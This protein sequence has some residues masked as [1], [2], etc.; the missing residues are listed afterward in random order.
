MNFNY[1]QP[2]GE[3]VTN[4]NKVIKNEI[5]NHRAKVKIV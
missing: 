4:I 1:N 3:Q 2:T 5:A